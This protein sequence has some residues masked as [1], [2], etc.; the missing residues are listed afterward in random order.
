MNNILV[1]R[2]DLKKHKVYSEER[3]EYVVPVYNIDNATPV[4]VPE[5]K[6]NCVLTMFGKCS[7]NETGCSD[8]KIKDK[9]RKALDEREEGEWLWVG[10]D[11]DRI[12]WSCSFCGRGVENQEN[13]CPECGRKIQ[14]ED[15]AMKKS[16]N[17]CDD[18]NLADTCVHSLKSLTGCRTTKCF[19][20]KFAEME[21]SNETT[22]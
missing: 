14:V 6:V 9:I 22:N 7:Y 17:L 1:N 15:K 19:R 21:A 8:C 2:E 10:F 16:D 13:F 12:K 4:E 11:G 3:H 20:R 5:N 18:C